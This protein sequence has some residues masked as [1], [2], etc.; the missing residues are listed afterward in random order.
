MKKQSRTHG[1]RLTAF[2][3]FIANS[4]FDDKPEDQVWLA[5]WRAHKLPYCSLYVVAP[6]GQW[7][8][9]VG[10]SVNPYKRLI[11]LQTSV[12]KPLKVM[13]CYWTNSVAEARALE[14]AVHLRLSDDNVWLH[15]EWFDMRPK[16]ATEMIEFVSLVEGIEIFDKIDNEE[17]IN[18]IKKDMEVR[19]TSKMIK[20]VADIGNRKTLGGDALARLA[21][22]CK[23]D[24]MMVPSRI[25]EMVMLHEEAEEDARLPSFRGK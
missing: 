16:A 1:L 21:N 24:G 20:A 10:I 13:R 19:F 4:N 14:K 17:V 18:S 5:D 12:W 2:D 25:A 8:C 9:K 15:G 7:P 11:G 23:E 22:Q 3:S 6:D